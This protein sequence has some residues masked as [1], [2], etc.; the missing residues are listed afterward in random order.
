MRQDAR[1]ERMR[2]IER[3]ALCLLVGQ[4]YGATTMAA[5]A[6]AAGASFE[7][8]YKWYGDKQGLFRAMVESNTEA[9]REA[10]GL[11]PAGF[12]DPLALLEEFGPRLIS[13]LTSDAVV[14]LNRAAAADPSGELGAIIAEAG[15]GTIAPQLNA[16]F[17]RAKA[18]GAPVPHDPA[19]ATETYLGLLLGDLQIRRVVGRV[20]P[21]DAAEIRRRSDRALKMLLGL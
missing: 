5:V 7:T 18:Q 11:S 15:R 2:E 3:T 13:V 8:L 14:E 21:P 4:G 6:K 16:L 20:P 12:A 1:Q 9:L 17:E 19:E 10:L